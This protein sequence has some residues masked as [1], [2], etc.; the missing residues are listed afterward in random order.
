MECGFLGACV[1]QNLP[2]NLPMSSITK[3]SSG[4]RAQVYVRGERDSAT[5]R[6]RREADAWASRRETEL[7]AS[8]QKSPGDKTT[9]R[10]VLLRYLNDVVPSRRG[11]K[12]E[13]IRIGRFLRAGPLDACLP[14]DLP[15]SAVTPEHIAAW[16]DARR[17]QVQSSTVLRELSLLSSVLT[18]ARIEWRLI[19]QNPISDVRKPAQKD[20]R[21]VTISGAQIRA[22]LRQMGYRWGQRPNTVG[23]A[24]ACL[25]LAAL[26]TGMRAGELCGLTWDRVYK[27][28]CETP[29]KTGA[30][31]SSLR[32]V[33]LEPR[34]RRLIERLKGW[35]D[36]FVFGIES[37]SLDALFR[38]YRQRAGLS[39][40]TFH[41]SRHTAATWMAKRVDVLTLCKIFGWRKMDQALTYYNPTASDIAAGLSNQKQTR[42]GQSPISG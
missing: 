16:R 3:S 10:K 20:H 42:R 33:P 25:F 9:L 6:T 2:V 35:D 1:T 11:R 38:K 29:H 14:L 27:D 41:D 39:G 26:H 15:I 36:K 4:Y 22:M 37:A 40:F 19:A 12:W 21:T 5:F 8:A 24:A 34:S 13:S 18:Q 31:A 30:T 23:Q 17:N 7:R 28:Y 32:A